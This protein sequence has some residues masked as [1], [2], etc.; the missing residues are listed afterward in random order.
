MYEL[1]KTIIALR[2]AFIPLIQ[3]GIDPIEGFIIGLTI[4]AMVTVIWVIVRGIVQITKHI[5]TTVS[6]LLGGIGQF[7]TKCL[8]GMKGFLDGIN[9]S[10][11]PR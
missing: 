5:V 9:T 7:I 2:E 8:R 4:V 3:D 11:M 1:K 10:T 6:Y